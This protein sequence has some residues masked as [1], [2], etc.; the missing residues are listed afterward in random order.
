MILKH[1]VIEKMYCSNTLRKKILISSKEGSN[2]RSQWPPNKV[3]NEGFFTVN[4]LFTETNYS[5]KFWGWKRIINSSRLCLLKE[6]NNDWIFHYAKVTLVSIV[7]THTR[8]GGTECVLFP[9]E[10]QN[11][12]FAF[13]VLSYVCKNALKKKFQVS[14]VRLFTKVV[15][16]F[17]EVSFLTFSITLA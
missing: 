4:D 14:Y 13:R 2:S 6:V 17:P 1:V 9:F 8:S 12:L 7:I 15:Q 11:W 3:A 5:I 10:L 16:F